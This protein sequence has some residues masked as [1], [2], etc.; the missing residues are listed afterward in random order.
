VRL[1]APEELLIAGVEPRCDAMAWAAAVSLAEEC[2]WL[3]SIRQMQG[4]L[5]GYL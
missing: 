4:L 1:Y 5:V 3:W 2:Q